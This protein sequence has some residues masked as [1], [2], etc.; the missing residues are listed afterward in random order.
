MNRL[1]QFL[2][3]L[4]LTLLFIGT[5]HSERP[6]T[7][8]NV[9]N[10]PNVNVK[11]TVNT[12]D[13]DNAARSPFQVTL[14]AIVDGGKAPDFCSGAPASI[15][16]DSNRRTV[17]EF[18]SGECFLGGEV[19]PGLVWIDTTVGS[20]AASHQI[21]FEQS[22]LNAAVPEA[23]QVTRIYADPG[24]TIGLES[25]LGIGAHGG[26]AVCKVTLSGHTVAM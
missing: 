5:A 14:C 1:M 8:T 26:Y 23:A 25:S 4:G 17:I 20:A 19:T 11:G 22:A 3:G 6:V 9:V 2:G 15:Q 16:A 12:K 21:H 18:V 10:T 24:T 7:N 13:A